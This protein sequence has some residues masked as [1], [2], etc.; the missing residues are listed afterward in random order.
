MAPKLSFSLLIFEKSAFGGMILVLLLGW[1]F[2][3]GIFF[4]ASFV[5]LD[6]FWRF[7]CFV[8]YFLVLPLFCWILFGASFVIK[9]RAKTPLVR[10]KKGTLIQTFGS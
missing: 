7:L 1:C 2:I 10:E 9:A 3:F 6:T 4:G 8:G 5:L